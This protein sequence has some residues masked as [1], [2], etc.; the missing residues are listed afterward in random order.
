[1][2]NAYDLTKE[3]I[4]V[5]VNIENYLNEKAQT[6]NEAKLDELDLK[7]TSLE[8]RIFEI[9]NILKLIKAE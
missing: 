7:I 6:N 1:M 4:S 9:K 8:N 5:A 2:K 3:F